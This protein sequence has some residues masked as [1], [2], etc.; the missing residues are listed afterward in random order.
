MSDDADRASEL[1]QLR[2]SRALKAQREGRPPAE[3]PQLL[4]GKRI[5][6]DCGFPIEKKRLKAN[7]SA[8]RCT[9]CQ[10]YHE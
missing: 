2:L 8:V 5:C 3:T 4:N 1:E 9:E 7:P 10:S 6:K